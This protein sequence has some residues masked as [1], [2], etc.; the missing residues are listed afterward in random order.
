[1][2]VRILV[3]CD[4]EYVLLLNRRLLVERANVACG[5]VKVLWLPLLLELRLTSE[6]ALQQ[7]AYIGLTWALAKIRWSGRL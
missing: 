3:I 1:M 5:L 4:V 7:R 2:T 6:D